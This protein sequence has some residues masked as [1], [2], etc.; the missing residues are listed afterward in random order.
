MQWFILTKTERR[1]NVFQ[2]N[3]EL[4]KREVCTNENRFSFNST[5]IAISLEKLIGF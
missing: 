5:I 4:Y 1:L 3:L 2:E